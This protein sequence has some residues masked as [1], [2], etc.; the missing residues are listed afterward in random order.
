MSLTATEAKRLVI[1]KIGHLPGVAGIGLSWDDKGRTCVRVNVNP[2]EITPLVRERI[3]QDVEG[4]H[5][6]VVELL[7]LRAAGE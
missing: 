7:H 1:T 3:P 2:L 6:E 5:V 4:V